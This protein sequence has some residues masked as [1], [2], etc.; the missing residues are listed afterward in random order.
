MVRVNARTRDIP[1]ILL[2]T[3]DR[4]EDL[5]WSQRY[6]A[7]GFLTKPSDLSGYESMVHRFTTV[8]FPKLQKGMEPEL[9]EI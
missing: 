9:K 3:S 5:H 8:D 6:H 2:S 4:P 7:E 1:V